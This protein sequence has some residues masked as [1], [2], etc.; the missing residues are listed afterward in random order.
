M[1]TS[2]IL[3][4]T[5]RNLGMRNKQGCHSNLLTLNKT[6]ANATSVVEKVCEKSHGI[7]SEIQEINDKLA[8]YQERWGT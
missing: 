6:L 5:N 8:R 2:E 3:E 7:E 4:A 1:C